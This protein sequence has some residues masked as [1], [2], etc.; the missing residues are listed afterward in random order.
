MICFAEIVGHPQTQTVGINSTVRFTCTSSMSND[1]IFSWT[2][3]SRLL[4]QDNILK[5]D[6]S[7]IEIVGADKSNDGRYV[8]IVSSGSLM[9]LS[10]TATLTVI[11]GMFVFFCLKT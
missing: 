7:T 2:H 11:T 1:L 10:N 3:N 6:T 8:C 4:E 5:G 9:T